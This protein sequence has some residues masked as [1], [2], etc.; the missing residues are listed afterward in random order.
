MRRYIARIRNLEQENEDLRKNQRPQG[1]FENELDIECDFEENGP[2]YTCS[3][4]NLIVTKEN[5]TINSASGKHARNKRSDDVST[6]TITDQNVKYIPT[7]L[8]KTF[9]L[10][11]RLVIENSKLSKLSHPAFEN[12]GH[13]TIL[14]IRGNKI[15]HIEPKFFDPVDELVELYLPRNEIKSLPP[16]LFEPLYKLK[17]IDL[18]DNEITSVVATLIPLKNSVESFAISN[19]NLKKI[20]PRL[21]KRIGKANMIDFSSNEC[22]NMKFNFGDEED[23][24]KVLFGIIAMNCFE[25]DDEEFCQKNVLI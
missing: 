3:A 7:G 20:D 8:Y 24:K 21:S 6:I 9:P 23:K 17:I 15:I 19:N 13:I 5:S 16:K 4:K 25:H 12:L 10:L 22:I 14:D 1:C 18:S 11:K 2:E